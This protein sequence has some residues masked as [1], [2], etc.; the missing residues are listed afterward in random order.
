MPKFKLEMSFGLSDALAAM[1][2]PDLFEGDKADLS[3]ITGDK[4]LCVSAVI[5]KAFVDVCLQII[6][7]WATI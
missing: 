2:M 1:G 5:H 6:L 4:S 3:N 7:G